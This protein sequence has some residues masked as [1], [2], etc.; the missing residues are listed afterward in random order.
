MR[1]YVLLLLSSGTVGCSCEKQ[2]TVTA[3]AFNSTTAQTDARPLDTACGTRLQ[4][5]EQVVAVSRDLA[6][7][8]LACGTKLTIDALEGTWTVVD[9]TSARHERLID[10]YM[11]H[12]VTR[13]RQ[14]GIRE[15]NIRWCQP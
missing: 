7:L 14:W 5:G 15:V 3:A 13:A 8:G 10:I 12:D 4:P 6:A 1:S 2:L 9:L 11:G